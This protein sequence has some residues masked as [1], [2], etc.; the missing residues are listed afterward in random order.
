MIGLEYIAKNFQ[1]E[2]KIIAER[3]EISPK[4]VN[5]W[6][7]GRKKI[8][9]KRLKQLAGVFDLKEDYFQKELSRVEEIEVQKKNVSSQ[10]QYVEREQTGVDEQGEVY[11]YVT[12]LSDSEGILQ[13]LSQEQERE[14]LLSEINKIVHVDNGQPYNVNFFEDI[15]GLVKDDSSRSLVFSLIGAMSP[16]IGNAPYVGRQGEKE[17]EFTK[18]FKELLLKFG[19]NGRKK[20][21]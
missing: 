8:P 12:S 17:A 21:L 6:V 19:Y 14:I 9:I 16:Y 11:S 4:T 1:M 13:L 10:S 7:K 20:G 3:L 18:A 2:F 5:D 15:V